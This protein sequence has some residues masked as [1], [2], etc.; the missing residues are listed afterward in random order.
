MLKLRREIAVFFRSNTKTNSTLHVLKLTMVTRYGARQHTT[1][2][3]TKSGES[4]KVRLKFSIFQR[5]SY[6]DVWRNV[7]SASEYLLPISLF[8]LL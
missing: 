4:V 2:T 5:H 7:K 3:R 8:G 1:T 6:S